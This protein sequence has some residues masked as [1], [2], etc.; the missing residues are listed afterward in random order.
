[1]KSP[2]VDV[3]QPSPTKSKN[4][5]GDAIK[6][7][8]NIQCDGDVCYIKKDNNEEH[9]ETLPI[10]DGHSESDEESDDNSIKN[11][12]NEEEIIFNAAEETGDFQDD[13]NISMQNNQSIKSNESELYEKSEESEDLNIKEKLK[14][15]TEY[16][17]TDLK[18]MCKEYNIKIM[19]WDAKIKKVIALRKDQI[20]EKIGEYLGNKK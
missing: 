10:Y 4:P 9:S 15:I 6:T 20:Y 13:N 19:L 3:T 14:P 8:K 12:L 18:K 2:S 7:N 1:L 11:K 16:K 17:M 5:I